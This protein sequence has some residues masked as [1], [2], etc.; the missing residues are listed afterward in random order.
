M[1]FDQMVDSAN[2]MLGNLIVL[3]KLSKNIGFDIEDLENVL[4]VIFEACNT[5]QL[6]E[7]MRELYIKAA[8]SPNAN[9]SDEVTEEWLATNPFWFD[10]Y[11]MVNSNLYVLATNYKF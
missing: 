11:E 4:N 3:V 5:D 10:L 6:L 2:K 9:G 1:T 7:N 8:L